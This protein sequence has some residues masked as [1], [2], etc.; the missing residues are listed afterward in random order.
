M[1]PTY[2]F[3]AIIQKAV[4]DGIVPG[5]VLYARNKDGTLTYS[6]ATGHASLSPSNPRPMDA[7]TILALASM[8]KLLTS[9]CILQLLESP[10]YSSSF[11]LGLDTPV[12]DPSFPA[13][14]LPDLASLPI[15]S[16]TVSDPFATRSRTKHI[17][18]RHLLTHTSG[19]GYTFLQPQLMAWN[20]WKLA[21]ENKT[22]HLP[23]GTAFASTVPEQFS[24]PLLFEPGE[25][26]AYGCGIDW[27][28]WLLEKVTGQTLD[29]YMQENLVKKLGLERGLITFYPERV[30]PGEVENR[31]K[32]AE[33]GKRVGGG[34]DNDLAGAASAGNSNAEPGTGEAQGQH[35]PRTRHLDTPQLLNPPHRGAFGGQGGFADLAAYCEVVYSLLVDDERLLKKETAKLLFEGQIKEAQAKAALNENM[36]TPQWVVGYVEVPAPDNE[37]VVYDWSAGGLLVDEPGERKKVGG[38]WRRKGYLGWGGIFNLT[39][40]VDREAGVCG[41]FGAQTL[42]PADPLIEPLIKEFEREIFEKHGAK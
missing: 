38:R 42:D 5:V 22:P 28:G 19:C 9:I 34:W 20:E 21:Q 24:W 17:T 18:I 27:S 25:G 32:V 37:G 10:N 13:T 11:P 23:V 8:T 41:V 6:H 7:H 33:M 39:W 30:W 1:A 40:F 3:E 12:T 16:P 2:D 4:D 26:W 29:E 15:L 31:K 14:Y 35:H 36:K